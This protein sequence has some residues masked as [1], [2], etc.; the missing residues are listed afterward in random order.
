MKTIIIKC[1]H[2]KE[3]ILMAVTGTHDP[4]NGAKFEYIIFDEAIKQALKESEVK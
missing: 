3:Q 2:C 4:I 1:P